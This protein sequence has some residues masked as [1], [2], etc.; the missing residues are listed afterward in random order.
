MKA[1]EKGLKGNNDFIIHEDLHEEKQVKESGPPK[2]NKELN[3]GNKELN[4][5]KT[6]KEVQSK[7]NKDEKLELSDTVIP[8]PRQPLKDLKVCDTLIEEEA[9]S[10]SYSSVEEISPMSIESV[11]ISSP[12]VRHSKPSLQFLYDME[13]YRQDIFQYL[14]QAEVS[15]IFLKLDNPSII[16]KGEFSL[17]LCVTHLHVLSILKLLFI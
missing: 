7:E 10:E 17:M 14:L 13:E 4:N 3:N 6:K 12:L 11:R 1:A 5:R 8:V 16:I 2:S 15:I 9:M